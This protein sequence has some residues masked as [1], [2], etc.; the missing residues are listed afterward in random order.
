MTEQAV[1]QCIQEALG[2]LLERINALENRSGSSAP[3]P[4][5]PSRNSA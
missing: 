5:A 1:A 4:D 3:T 2:P